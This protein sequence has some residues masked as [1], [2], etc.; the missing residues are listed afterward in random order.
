MRKH[1]CFNG[2]AHFKF[3]RI[4]LPVSPACNI[5]CGYCRRGYNKWEQRPGVSRGVLT[6]Q[7]A[8][9]TLERALALC[10]EITV[11]GIAGPGDTLATDHALETFRLIHQKYPQIINCLSTNGL[12]LAEKAEQVAEA[13]VLTITVTV[14]AVDP[15]IGAQIYEEVPVAG[16]RQQGEGAAAHLINAQ[17]AGIE[18]AAR[19]GLTVKVNS[20]LIPGINDGQIGEVAKAAAEAGASNFNIIPLIPQQ[21]FL[22]HRAPD[23]QELQAAREAAE[24]HLPVF[25]HCHQC[26]ADACGIPGKG[27]DLAGQLYDRPIETFSHG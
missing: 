18:A 17:L 9:Q 23:C 12:R 5:Q 6:P 11:A 8:L 27:I 10:P 24:Q 2:E 7:E 13:G 14:N 20:V 3:G 26:R 4:H 15:A 22:H 21:A 25:R 1:P 16:K 19:L